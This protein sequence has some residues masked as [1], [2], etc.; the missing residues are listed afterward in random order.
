MGPNSSSPLEQVQGA[1]YRVLRSLVFSVDLPGP[2]MQLP[3][4]QLRCLHTVSAHDGL[5]MQELADRMGIK[6]PAVSQMVDRLVRKGLVERIE[7][8]SDRRVVRVRSTTCSQNLMAAHKAQRL[9][10]LQDVLSQMPP[11]SVER[12][13]AGLND[14]AD[15]AVRSSPEDPRH[16]SRWEDPLE[17]VGRNAAMR[18][19]TSLDVMRAA[20]DHK[21]RRGRHHKPSESLEREPAEPCGPTSAS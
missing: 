4:A 9:K 16:A 11:E 17:L 7:D 18:A 2:L 3:M 5:R 21:S 10:R 15:A 19:S 12:V 6:L 20:D 1:L 8:A 14:L 13:I